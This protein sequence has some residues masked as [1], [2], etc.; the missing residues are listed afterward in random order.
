[1]LSDNDRCYKHMTDHNKET[2]YN[3]G[4]CQVIALLKTHICT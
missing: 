3:G 4:F 2:A 1:M